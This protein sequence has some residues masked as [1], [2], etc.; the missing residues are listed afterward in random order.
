MPSFSLIG[1]LEFRRVVSSLQ[2]DAAATS[3]NMFETPISPYPGGHYHRHH[4][5]HMQRAH[6]GGSRARTPA[7]SINEAQDPWDAVLARSEQGLLLA[8][9]TSPRASLSD[10]P[11]DAHLHVPAFPALDGD[12]ASMSMSPP[13]QVQTQLPVATSTPLASP[14]Y[15]GDADTSIPTIERTPATPSEADMSLLTESS[16]LPYLPPSRRQRLFYRVSVVW[17]VLF[18]TLHGFWGKSPLGMVAAVFAAPAVM[19]LTL[20]LPVVVSEHGSDG[21][22]SGEKLDGFSIE[23]FEVG[24]DVPRL[25]EFEEESVGRER[26][27]LVADEDDEDD[28]DSVVHEL[29]FNK[30]LMAVQC[31]LGPLFCVAILFGAS[32]LSLHCGVFCGVCSR[33]RMYRTANTPQEPWILLA[34]GI[35]GAAMGILVAVFAH[36]GDHPAARL[37]RCTMGFVVAIVWIMAIADE[38][39]EVLQ[40]RLS[41][42]FF[43]YLSLS[44]NA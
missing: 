41:L 43:M 17:H 34:T 6:S 16:V 5:H 37:A 32:R 15:A 42:L 21:L 36:Q 44:P 2:H 20:T 39:V 27:T 30:W 18:P 23:E 12:P 19:A 13:T 22:H 38:V 11:R 25:V 7:A 14:P 26:L 1:A 8:P 40:V 24:R 31:V 35:A 3:L 28:E 4:S 10:E 33:A 9:R 29:K